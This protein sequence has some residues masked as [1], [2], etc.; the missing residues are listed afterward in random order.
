MAMLNNQRVTIL[1]IAIDVE[2]TW[3]EAL[4][5]TKM[6]GTTRKDQKGTVLCYDIFGTLGCSYACLSL[7]SAFLKQPTQKGKLQKRTHSEQVEAEH[8]GTHQCAIRLCLASE[9]QQDTH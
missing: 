1:M 2:K 9:L 6:N 5:N 7:A 4:V 8:H 3:F